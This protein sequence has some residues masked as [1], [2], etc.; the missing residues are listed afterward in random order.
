MSTEIDART[1]FAAEFGKLAR[2]G[3]AWLQKQRAAAMESFAG[4]PTPDLE[5]WRFTDVAPIAERT[6]TLD[7][8][9][10]APRGFSEGPLKSCQIA[11]VNGRFDAAHSCLP[12]GAAVRAGLVEHEPLALPTPFVLL[13]RALATDGAVIEVER[14]V[15][16]P[17][18]VLHVAAG[19]GTA[20][21]PRTRVV[22]ARGARATVVESFV[23]AGATFTDAVTEIVVGEN[24]SIDHHRLQREHTEAYHV[25]ALAVRQ[26]ANSRFASHSIALG[27]ALSRSEIE[28][29]L[30]GEGAECTLNGLYEVT[31]SQHVDNHT[32]IVHASPHTTSRELYKGI[33]DGHARAVFDG[34]I[35]V[36][37]AAQKTNAMQSNKNLLLSA[38]ALVNTKPQLEIFANDVKCKHGA[39]IGQLDKDML[40]YIRSRG[41]GME[42]ARRLLVHAFASEI[43]DAIRDDAVRA[44]MTGCLLTMVR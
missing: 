40:F 43:M 15:D 30:E 6:W 19:E 3:P 28:A 22:A 36:K 41:L 35:V 31:G 24:G 7:G 18:H 34:K 27:A 20:N 14:S 37:P 38:D 1:Q 8:A 29:V 9:M 11:F 2:Q 39:T 44:Q 21:F 23:G 42:E 32:S 33:L 13:N 25:H 4:F 5:D 10:A 12:K 26:G 16:V 17:I